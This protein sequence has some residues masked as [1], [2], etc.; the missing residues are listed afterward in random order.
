MLRFH[1]LNEENQI[2]RI[3][4]GNKF[5]SFDPLSKV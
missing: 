5:L 1:F 2:R 3:C 4:Y